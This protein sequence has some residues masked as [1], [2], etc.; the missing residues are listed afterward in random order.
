MITE[1]GTT[2]RERLSESKKYESLKLSLPPWWKFS[3]GIPGCASELRS[4]V[5]LV[6]GAG[7]DDCDDD[8]RRK[9]K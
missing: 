1:R 3:A 4:D 6:V 8:C 9:A 7:S 2:R 5:A